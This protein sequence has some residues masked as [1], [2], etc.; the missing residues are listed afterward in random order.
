[1]KTVQHNY[2][3]SARQQAIASAPTALRAGCLF[4]TIILVAMLTVVATSCSHDSRG[5]NNTS[6]KKNSATASDSANQ[7][8]VNIQ[9]NRK[10]DDKGNLIGF[11]STYSSYYSNIQDDTSRMDSLMKGFDK[12][13][14]SNY[15]RMFDQ[16]FNTLFF[17][18]S[19]RYPDFFHNDFFMKRYELND[20]YLRGMMQHMDSI[21]NRFYREAHK[22]PTTKG[23]K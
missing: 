22:S 12:Y 4:T 6:I 23:K 17:N 5:Q 21:K 2:G 18:D 16:Q 13:F 14:G 11:D 1:M 9:V 15:S 7:P 3:L 20:K 8:K 19:L 10:Y